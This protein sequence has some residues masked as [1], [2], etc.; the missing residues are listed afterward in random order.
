MSKVSCVRI[1]ERNKVLYCYMGDF[2]GRVQN[3]AY[4]S[5]LL[6]LV[7][8]GASAREVQRLLEG[9]ADLRRIGAWKSGLQWPAD[10]AVEL[11]VG[12]W[13]ARVDRGETVVAQLRPGPGRKGHRAT[14]KQFRQA[15]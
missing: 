7:A 1:V 5:E 6:Q 2:R 15:A 9:R 4:F 14:L 11:L 13:R 10:W 8:P 3:G 12:K